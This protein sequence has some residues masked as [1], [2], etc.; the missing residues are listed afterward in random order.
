MRPLP[1]SLLCSAL[2]WLAVSAGAQAALRDGAAVADRP[3]YDRPFHSVAFAVKAGT[4]GVGFDVATPLARRLNLRA[5]LQLFDYTANF[6]TDGISGAG[7]LTLSNTAVSVDYFPFR[8]SF[9]LSP[10]ITLHNDNHIAGP[11]F[12]APGQTFTL[13]DTDYTS[14]PNDP[15]QGFARARFGAKLAPRFTVGWGNMLARHD[16]EG[17]SERRAARFSVPVEIGFQVSS[18]P[19]LT[20]ALTG[21]GCSTDGCAP[22][23]SGDGAANI[24]AEIL[25]LQNDLKPLRFFPILS[26][27]L[28]FRLGR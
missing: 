26:A 9:H 12:V 23:N 15:L 27:G 14:D 17:R 7:D 20:L 24:Q 25:Q 1:V 8:N 3:T 18:A 16:V 19:T 11:I 10:G 5:G 4:T 13:G 21:S 2:V 28:A 6:T 22:I